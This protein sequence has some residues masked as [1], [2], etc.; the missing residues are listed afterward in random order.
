MNPSLVRN[1]IVYLIAVIIGFALFYYYKQRDDKITALWERNKFT[2][3]S[4]HT[5]AEEKQIARQFSDSLLPALKEK[6]LVLAVERNSIQTIISVNG[7]IWK[8]RSQ[9]FKET[10][11]SYCVTYNRVNGFSEVIQ[12]VDTDSKKILAEIFSNGKKEIYE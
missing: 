6:G 4:I 7:T 11:L 8:E 1:I 12:I 10:L 9:F 2:V 3:D 5:I